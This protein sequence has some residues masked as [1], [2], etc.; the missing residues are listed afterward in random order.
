[1]EQT[2]K[3]LKWTKL[4]KGA[5]DLN[6]FSELVNLKPVYTMKQTPINLEQSNAKYCRKAK[7]IP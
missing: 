7:S 2:L 1:M 3:N 5:F 6:I 4:R